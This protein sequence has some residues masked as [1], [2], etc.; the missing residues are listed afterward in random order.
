MK[1]KAEYLLHENINFF[2]TED[3]G[4]FNPAGTAKKAL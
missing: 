4:A 2:E 1:P 3:R